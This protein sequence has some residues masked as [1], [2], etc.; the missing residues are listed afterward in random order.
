MAVHVPVSPDMLQWLVER[1]GKDPEDFR[2]KYPRWDAWL[3]RDGGPTM[4]Q[5]NELARTAGVPLGYLLLPRPPH[6]ELPV[7]DFR[8]GFQASLGDPS[9]DLLA[10][11]NEC[12]SRQDWY[13]DYAEE[14]CLN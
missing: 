7:P 14:Y 12:I 2:D 10:V 3:T 8:E 4:R 11:V 5:A 6:L 9:S 13:R 1:S